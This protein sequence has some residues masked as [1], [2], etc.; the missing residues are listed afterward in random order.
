M[1]L[2]YH[3][4]SRVVPWYCQGRKRL[5][6]AILSIANAYTSHL[7]ANAEGRMQNEERPGEATSCDI[8]ATSRPVDSQLI[9]PPKPP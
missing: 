1:V 3:G 8:N 7:G 4:R 5:P 2:W 6:G 9:A